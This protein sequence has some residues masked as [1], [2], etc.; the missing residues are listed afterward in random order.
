[1]SDLANV[2]L[3]DALAYDVWARDLAAGN[4]LG[5]EV[6]YQAPLYAYFLGTLYTIGGTS[7]AWVRG[8]QIVLGATTCLLLALTGKRLFGPR[9]GLLSGV[10]LALN[11]AAVYFDALV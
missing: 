10:L 5:N 11:P 8:V 2:L 7:L 4:W 6:Y 3:G 9:A 1:G